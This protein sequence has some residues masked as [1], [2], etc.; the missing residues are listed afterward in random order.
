MEITTE[1]I[2]TL[3]NKLQK[4]LTPKRYLHTLGV[5]YL[6]AALAMRHGVNHRVALV[7]GLLH[8]CAKHYPDD[9][10]Q[11]K[12]KQLH[13]DV[14]EHELRLPQLL[15]APYGAYLAQAEYKI[16]DLNIIHAIRN[17]TVGRPE[18]SK[19][20]QIVFLADYMEPE[21]T[22]TT[23]PDLDE[24]RHIAFQDLNKAT[25]LVLENTLR[26]FETTK[27]DT[28]PET[29]QTSQYYKEI[30]EETMKKGE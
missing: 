12:C 13:L 4:T 14:S 10:L 5:A 24:L 27:Q 9:E 17:H 23:N 26:Y 8:D 21:R 25:Y 3:E 2:L 19:L 22:Q 28:A 18:M 30:M 6:S 29:Y 15:H 11:E 1:Y 16:T 7:A 20:E